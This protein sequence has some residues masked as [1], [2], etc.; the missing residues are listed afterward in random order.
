MHLSNKNWKIKKSNKMANYNLCVLLFF[1]L[2]SILFIVPSQIEKIEIFS[3]SINYKKETTWQK[4]L[5]NCIQF[6]FLKL[7]NKRSLFFNLRYFHIFHSDYCKLKSKYK[8]FAMLFYH[9]KCTDIC[10]SSRKYFNVIICLHSLA[11][12]KLNN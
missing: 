5:L 10:H 4:A 8:V 9:C 3:E 1:N 12:F 7:A 11:R 6:F 2:F